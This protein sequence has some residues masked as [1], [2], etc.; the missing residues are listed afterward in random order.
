MSAN[1]FNSGPIAP[2]RNVPIMPGYFEPRVF[3]I[4]AI[5]LGVTTVVTIANSFNYSIGQEVRFVIPP[6]YGCQ[7]ITGQT[8]FVIGLPASNQITVQINSTNYNAFIP[9]PSYGP[10]Q[11]Q[12]LAIGDVNSGVTTFIS[13]NNPNIYGIGRA[14]TST[15]I[16]GSFI[17]TSPQTT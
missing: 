3:T 14:I 8:G 10:T 15:A 13:V 6:T 9:S 16:P 12:I 11:P 1:P 4:T 7:Q 17:N 5:A 2:Y